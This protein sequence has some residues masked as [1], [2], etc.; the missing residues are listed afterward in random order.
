MDIEGQ[1]DIHFRAPAVLGKLS[2]NGGTID[3]SD[4]IVINEDFAW[5]SGSVKGI[6]KQVRLLNRLSKNCV[7]KANAVLATNMINMSVK[8]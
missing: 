8:W 3:N 7:N 4:E 6:W 5:T 2:L 1:A